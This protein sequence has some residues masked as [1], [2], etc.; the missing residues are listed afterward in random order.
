VPEASQFFQRLAVNKF[1]L[2]LIVALL[3]PGMAHA[4]DALDPDDLAEVVVTANTRRLFERDGSSGTK[5]G[6][7]LIETPM[8]ISV[9]SEERLEAQNF[10]NIAD[11]LKYV[12][13]AVDSGNTWEHSDGYMVRGFDQ[14]SF[15]LLDGLLRNDPGWWSA[16]EPFGIERVE[17]IKGPASVLY[18]QSPPG[19]MVAMTSKRPGRNAHDKVEVG[20]GNDGHYA[21]NLDLNGELADGKVE[22]RLIVTYME[23]GDLIRTVR[24]DRRV[25]QPSLTWKIGDAT[26]LTVLGLRQTDN[27]DYNT[28]VSAYGTLFESPHGPF[29]YRTYLGEPNLKDS[30]K[31]TQNALGYELKH[32]FNDAWSLQQ[33]FRYLQS[34]V[35]SEGVVWLNGLENIGNLSDTSLPQPD[36]RTMLRGVGNYKQDVRNYSID[37]M[38]LGKFQTGAVA[39]TA[40]IGLD[41]GRFSWDYSGGG[42]NISSI[43]IYQPVYSSGE[44]SVTDIYNWKY[45]SEPRQLAVYA[46]E[47][48]KV[49]SHLVLIAGGRYDYATNQD[50][51]DG[52]AFEVQEDS[53]FSGRVGALYIFDSGFSPYVSYAT[54]F[55]PTVG[56]DRLGAVFT[57]ETGKQAEIGLKYEMPGGQWQATLAVFDITRN[58]MLTKDPINPNFNVQLGEQRHRGA[59]FELQ[60]KPLAGLN[61]VA[62]FSQLDAEVVKGYEAANNGKRPY[63]VPRTTASFWGSYEL[64]FAA[65]NG[66]SVNLGMTYQGD[67]TSDEAG[68]FL[69]PSFM[70]WDAAVHYKRDA[71]RLSLN[72]EN[73]ANKQYISSCYTSDYCSRGERRSVVAS[74]TYQW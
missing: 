10:T 74:A 54:S 56:T 5:A 66:M 60:A 15:I 38:L 34:L 30:Y 71:W 8:A 29:D 70:L 18:G 14:S 4:A 63:G 28:D 52:A 65:L 48:V 22:G 42:G 17:I 9:I 72:A 69:V 13:G 2:N 27:D 41:Y 39:H 36:Y 62:T 1:G 57:P 43:D 12:A 68:T 37:T 40:L 67:A 24:F 31:I 59:E 11:S 51:S 32:S 35:G 23:E 7:P 61:V 26:T 73:V 46:Q 33:N 44:V 47:Q 49:F 16:S 50:S 25:F 19:G 45:H 6:T 64:P 55:L 3:V 21:A 53:A 58:K 20:Y